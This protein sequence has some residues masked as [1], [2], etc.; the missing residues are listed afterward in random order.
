MGKVKIFSPMEYS[1]YEFA[2]KTCWGGFAIYF[3]SANIFICFIALLTKIFS[4]FFF[5]LAFFH[6]KSN[7]QTKENFCPLV[8]HGIKITMLFIR[9]IF[10]PGHL[11][12]AKKTMSEC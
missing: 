10:F 5:R 12:S 2:L 8:I 6:F 3:V 9:V 7:R 4:I 1:I 11:E